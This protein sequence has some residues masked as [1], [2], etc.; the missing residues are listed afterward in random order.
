MVTRSRRGSRRTTRWVRYR[1]TVNA[2]TAGTAESSAIITSGDTLVGATI[3]RIVGNIMFHSNTV[4]TAVNYTCGIVLGPN[5]L[6][7]IDM[8]PAVIT[9]MDWMY[10][11]SK[12]SNNPAY[13]GVDSWV[14]VR[15]DVD[16]MGRRKFTE[17]D[18]L[19]Y[20]SSMDVSGN[21]YV[22]LSVLVLNP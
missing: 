18:T 8:D 5:S 9:S 16:L 1:N 2:L 14:G 3:L 17:G 21:E 13:D 19:W 6:D 22:N 20:A 7:A 4:D 10:W 12:G 11:S 15:W